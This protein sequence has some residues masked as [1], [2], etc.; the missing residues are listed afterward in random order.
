MD[1]L[2]IK[3]AGTEVEPGVDLRDEESTGQQPE[4]YSGDESSTVGR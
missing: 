2:L 1:F 3:D 4:A